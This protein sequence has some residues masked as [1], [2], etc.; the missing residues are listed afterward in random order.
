MGVFGVFSGGFAGDCEG[1]PG[2]FEESGGGE[3]LATGQ[4]CG[5]LAVL[6]RVLRDE[7]GFD[8]EALPL[9]QRGTHLPLHPPI[10][11]MPIIIHT[12]PP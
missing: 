3:L 5:F 8:V 1:G 11:I 4:L 6:G 9:E 12:P 10:N 2:L 7:A